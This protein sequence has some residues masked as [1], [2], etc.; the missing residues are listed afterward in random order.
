MGRLMAENTMRIDA[1][2]LVPIPLHKDSKR[3]YNQTELIARGISEI[4]NIPTAPDALFWNKG[5]G[6]QTEKSGH[7]RKMLPYGSISSSSLNGGC[8]V[9]LV[10]DVYTTGATLRAAKF[11]AERSGAVVLGAMLWSRRLSTAE[12]SLS[13]EKTE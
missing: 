12:N 11:A 1:D 8:R 5:Q 3:E 2:L 13:W 9:V 7:L 4:W 6:R 10:D